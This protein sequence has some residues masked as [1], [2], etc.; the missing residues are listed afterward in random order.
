VNL[1]SAQS[2]TYLDISNM[3]RSILVRYRMRRDLYVQQQC[4]PL[5]GSSIHGYSLLELMMVV[6]VLGILAT[7]AV[8]NLL[9]AVRKEGLRAA[10]HAA[11]GFVVRA[12]L[13]AM[14]ERRCVRVRIEASTT[15][16]ALVAERLNAYDCENP[17]APLI[18]AAKPLWDEFARMRMDSA[19]LVLTL[20]TPPTDTPNE[21]RFRPNGR[22][23]SADDDL[24]DDDAV[25]AINHSSLPA[26]IVRIVVDAPAMVCT[27]AM[28]QEPLGTGNN[29]SCQ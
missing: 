22:M 17:G 9:P 21:M 19:A 8:P 5:D 7:L 3:M 4:R 2:E 26:S 24:T 27:L 11:A 15:P 13:T 23:F 25:I 20:A 16:M 14:A 12:R 28:G 18:I 1:K 10:G 6:A 29:L